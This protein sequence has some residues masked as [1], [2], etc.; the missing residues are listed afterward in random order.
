MGE[1][2]GNVAL[3]SAVAAINDF[4]PNIKLNIKEN[5]LYKV[6]QLVSTFTGYEFSK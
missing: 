3:E 1:R 2:A 5:S 4:I 6:S